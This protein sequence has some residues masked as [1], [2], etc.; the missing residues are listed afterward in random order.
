MLVTSSDD[1]SHGSLL[2]PRCSLRVQTKLHKDRLRLRSACY[3]LRRTFTW[4]AVGSENA[5][6]ELRRS[7]TWLAVGSADQQRPEST[8]SARITGVGVRGA[9]Q[10]SISRLLVMNSEGASLGPSS[11]PRCSLRVPL[12][13]RTVSL[14]LRSARFEFRRSFAW[15]AARSE[16]L[17]TSP[18]EASLGSLSAPKCLF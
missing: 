13:L 15:P 5:R 10:R 16:M 9:G 4:L 11:A 6:H 8:T 2:A 17:V 7:V 12:E 14:R 18:D 3:E 1:A